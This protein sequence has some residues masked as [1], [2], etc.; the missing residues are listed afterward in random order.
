MIKK[1]DVCGADIKIDEYGNGHCK[2]C[3]W[4]NVREEEAEKANYPNFLPIVDARKAYMQ[5]K[6]LLPTYDF[7]LD[8]LSRGFE[9]ALWY[10]NKKYGAMRDGD[11]FDFYLWNSWE[12]FQEYTTIEE[13][14]E[15]ANI[16]GKLLKEIWQDISRI[17]YDC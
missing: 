2:K 15:N 10:K 8:I 13:F 3:G 7:F 5:G 1:C 11:M 9:M 6:K 14:S 16:N 12:N 4:H 17:E